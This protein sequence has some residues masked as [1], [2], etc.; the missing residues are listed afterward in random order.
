MKVCVVGLGSMGKRRVRDLLHFRHEVRGV[1]VRAD[2]RQEAADTFGIAVHADLAEVA[3]DVEAVVI[4]TPPDVH[5]AYYELCGRLGLPFFSEAN[6]FTPR[7][8]WF[9]AR[10]VASYPSGTW[11]FHPLVQE[12]RRRVHEIGI[13]KVNG[14]QHHYAG[15]LPDWHPWEHYTDFYAGRR[16]TS[17]AR[18]MVP[19][20]IEFLVHVFGRV[21]AVS[22]VVRRARRW[23]SDIDDT[24]LLQL[25]FEQGFW[26]SVSIELHQVAAG[27]NT[28]VSLED[29]CFTLDLGEGRLQSYNRH[30]DAWKAQ[31]PRSYHDRWA[32]CFE[33]V[34]REEMRKFVAAASLGEPYP[35]TWDDDRHLSDILYAAE[36][37]SAERRAVTIAEAVDAYDGI[38]WI[39]E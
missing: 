1:D 19:F 15:F 8:D 5:L 24:Y 16:R 34:Y 32:F 22:A 31:R 18:E 27:R 9:R 30:D 25:E 12:L 38:S 17:A 2:R 35:K 21:R 13:G 14:V 20:E 10:S 3:G 11:L 29:D 39:N 4:S 37:S 23:S 33:D 7:A 36:R 28:R 6:I 26:G